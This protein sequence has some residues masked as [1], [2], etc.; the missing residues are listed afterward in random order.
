MVEWLML[1]NFYEELTTMSKGHV[2]ASAG[3]AFLSLTTDGAKALIEKMVANQSLGEE[4]KQQKG[5]HF[6]KEVDMLATKVDLLMKRLDDRAAEKEAMKSTVQAMESH[7]TF[8]VCG[9]VGHLGNVCP[10]TCE[11]ASYINNG[12]H[13]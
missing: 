13:Q 9:D 2:D 10:E 6:V 12:F 4:R 8:E 7:M 11:E 3:G 1:Q 5:M